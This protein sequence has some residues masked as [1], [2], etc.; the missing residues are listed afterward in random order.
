M[1][2]GSTRSKD[3]SL[4]PCERNVGVAPT[5]FSPAREPSV[6]PQVEDQSMNPDD[7][8]VASRLQTQPTRKEIQEHVLSHLP[9]R[10]WCGCL[11]RGRG[12][13]FRIFAVRRREHVVPSVSIDHYFMGPP[14]QEEAQDVLPMLAVKSHESRMTSRLDDL[15]QISISIGWDCGDWCSN[16]SGANDSRSSRLFENQ[17]PQLNL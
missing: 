5:D 17:C 7:K 8:R 15:L 13:S 6:R 2:S 1:T 12:T 4:A 11:L 10:S 14:G 9:P 3:F 16:Q